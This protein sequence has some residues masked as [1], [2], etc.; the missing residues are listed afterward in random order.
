MLTPA[1]TELIAI[2]TDWIMHPLAAASCTRWSSCTDSCPYYILKWCW[3][4]GAGWGL[5]LLLLRWRHRV[6]CAVPMWGIICIGVAILLVLLI[7]CVC[8]CKYCCCKRRKGKDGK[9]GAK[10]DGKGVIM[11]NLLQTKV[12]DQLKIIL[13]RRHFVWLNVIIREWAVC[14][15]RIECAT[16]TLQ[17][18]HDAVLR[19]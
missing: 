18:A 17:T 13:L 16:N 4:R 3:V 8:I 10:L 9:K 7:C 14:A 12:V 1:F 6:R 15:T 11:G 5:L 19:L 2:I